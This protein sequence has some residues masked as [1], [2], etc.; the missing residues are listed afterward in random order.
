MNS[1]EALSSIAFSMHYRCKPQYV[2]KAEEK[3]FE[4]IEKDLKVLEIIKQKK[5]DVGYLDFLLEATSNEQN[6]AFRS[7]N[8]YCEPEKYKKLTQEEF[9][10]IKDWL[11]SE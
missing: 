2:Y 9:D 6:F 3:N 1:L 8:G 11:R 7:Y 4:L 10:L 5:I